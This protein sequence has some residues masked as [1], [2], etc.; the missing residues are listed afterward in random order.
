M[1]LWAL[2]SK[3]AIALHGIRTPN[4]FIHY[5]NIRKRLNSR[6]PPLGYRVRVSV[7]RGERNGIWV[8]FSLD[9]SATIFVPPFLHTH[10]IHFVSFNP[11]FDFTPGLLGRHPC[12]SQIFNKG[13]FASHPSTRPCV[14]KEIAITPE[15]IR[16][17]R[18][19]QLLQ[20]LKTGIFLPYVP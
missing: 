9:F 19:S 8:D 6:L 14:I 10:L 15:L 5:L 16:I 7:I 18:R 20:R 3:E 12:Y 4:S 11:P 1:T 2:P 13:F 17:Y